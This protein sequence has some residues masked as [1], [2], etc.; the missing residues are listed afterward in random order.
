LSAD[1]LQQF[2]SE[3]LAKFKVPTIVTFTSESLPR[4]AAGKILKTALRN[5]AVA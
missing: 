2:L 4:N 1:E 5:A 3:R